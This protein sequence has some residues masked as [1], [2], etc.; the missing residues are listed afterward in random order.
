MGARLVARLNGVELPG[1]N[2]ARARE[3]A[4]A[5]ERAVVDGSL[6]YMLTVAR[7]PPAQ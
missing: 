1:S 5:A 6:G 2:L 3:L 4:S 7:K